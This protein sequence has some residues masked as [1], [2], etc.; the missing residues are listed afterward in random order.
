M[1][2]HV[3]SD[4]CILQ[5]PSKSTVI[6]ISL[7]STRCLRATRRREARCCRGPA[8]RP[9]MPRYILLHSEMPRYILLHSE[10]PCYIL[11]HSEIHRYILLHVLR[12]RYILQHVLRCPVTSCYTLRCPVTSC[13]TLR[14]LLQVICPSPLP[15]SPVSLLILAAQEHLALKQP[16]KRATGRRGGSERKGM[17]NVTRSTFPNVA[18]IPF[19]SRLTFC[20]ERTPGL[21]VWKSYRVSCTEPMLKASRLHPIPTLTLSAAVPAS[22]GDSSFC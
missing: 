21:Q 19:S 4:A 22:S 14:C 1:V 8:T 12:C 2:L 15:L 18:Q 10:M 16:N 5:L 20:V 11:L 3:L 9:A 7:D 17:I 13:Y 6:Q